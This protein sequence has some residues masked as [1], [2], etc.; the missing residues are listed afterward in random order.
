MVQVE[1]AEAAPPIVDRKLF[2]SLLFVSIFLF[3]WISLDPF[4]DLT[5]QS[6]ASISTD[7]SN[8]FNQLLFLCLPIA[9]AATALATPM[10]T[11]LLP[12]AWLV[13]LTFLW[14][15]LVSLISNHS[16][17]SFKA[18]VLSSLVLV[19]ANCCLLLPRSEPHLG[20]LLAIGTGAVLLLCYYGLR[21]MPELSIHSAAEVV[22]PMHAG[23]WRGYF[24]HKNNAAAAMVL[25]AFCALFVMNTWSRPIGVLLLAGAVWFLLHTGGKTASAMLPAILMLAWIFERFPLLRIPLAVGGVLLLNLFA[26]GAAVSPSLTGLV[27]SLG[28]DATFTNRA[29]VWRL[30]MNAIS[31]FP[32]TGYG[33][34]SFWRTEELVYGGSSIA[35]WAVTAAHSHNGYVEIL[36]TTGLPGLLLS[37]LWFLVVP[38]RAFGRIDRSGHVSHAAR[39]YLR[40][41]LY[42]IFGAGLES[43]FFESSS[44]YNLTWF[45]FGIALFGIQY[46]AD[47]QQVADARAGGSR[48]V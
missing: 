10:R 25:V 44:G 35:T 5:L 6:R 43:F 22:E 12:P 16:F 41:W 19:A 37:L 3:F 23:L 18:L 46:E 7:N 42:L 17:N 8:K 32:L 45:M 11:R 33:L 29:D 15:L 30:A 27:E 47:A 34:K 39:L 20:K 38:V 26:V 2:A 9:A 24:P 1:T 4:V 21:F 48:D 14:F 36:L 13:G 28:I 40:I 31:E